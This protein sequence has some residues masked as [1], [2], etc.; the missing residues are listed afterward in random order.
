MEKK[1]NE[2]EHKIKLDQ[3][4]N[5]EEEN[6][7]ENDKESKDED[8]NLDDLNEKF[9]KIISYLESINIDKEIGEKEKNKDTRLI[10]EKIELENFKSWAGRK[11]LYPLDT[12]IIKL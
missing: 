5:E 9:E 10:I 6:E 4:N 11:T 3:E 12:V 2:N 7:N 8:F 1:T